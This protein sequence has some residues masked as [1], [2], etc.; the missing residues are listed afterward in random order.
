M[1]WAIVGAGLVCAIAASSCVSEQQYKEAVSGYEREQDAKFAAQ[2]EM[3]RL[4]TEN[5]AL[6]SELSSDKAKALSAAWNDDIQKKMSDLQQMVAERQSQGQAPLKD[7]ERFDIPGVGYVFMIQDKVLFSSGSA[8]ISE[9]GKKSLKGLADQINAS[10]HGSVVVRGHTDNDPVVKQTTKERF[11]MGNLQLS[12]ERAVSV[13]AFMIDSKIP[14][15]Q[16]V[17]A[18]YGEWQ[19]VADNNSAENKR[20]NRRVEIFVADQ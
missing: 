9:E 3:E 15:Q 18:G 16:V 12:A 19:P 6:R 8:D 13:A 7:I 17:I 20:L 4:K 5:Q 10:Q 14:P 11:P 2:K 1:R